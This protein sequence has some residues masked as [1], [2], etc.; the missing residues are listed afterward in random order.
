MGAD[1]YVK[2][3]DRENQYRG[4]EVSQDAV[5]SGYFRDCYNSY[6]LFQVM[7]AT[8]GESLSWWQIANEEHLFRQDDEDGA[9]MTVE[10]IKLWKEKMFPLLK[11]FKNRKVLYRSEYIGGIENFSTNWANPKCHKKIKIQPEKVKEYH[12]WANLLINFIELAEKNNSEI[13]WSV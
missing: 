5:D 10:G 12:D 6:G 11:Q 2:K 8:L 1:L 4:F 3:M 13:I 7:S 9:V